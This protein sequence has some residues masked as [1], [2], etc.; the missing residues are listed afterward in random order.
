MVK[1]PRLGWGI[2]LQVAPNRGHRARELVLANLDSAST[3]SVREPRAARGDFRAIAQR[4]PMAEPG[5]PARDQ[6][7]FVHRV[8]RGLR[9]TGIAKSN[10][11]MSQP[12][13]CS[14]IKAY[15][16]L[17]IQDISRLSYDGGVAASHFGSPCASR[18]I[19]AIQGIPPPTRIALAIRAPNH[20]HLELTGRMSEL[21]PRS[22][23]K[24]PTW[25]DRTAART[26]ARVY[27]PSSPVR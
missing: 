14:Y 12:N 7:A 3:V 17:I 15:I 1:L 27:N 25:A 20:R 18:R 9:Q 16:Y 13:Y 10:Y 2:D 4:R 5:V 6:R 26:T 8:P 22:T 23:H 19:A 11:F 24:P 21:L